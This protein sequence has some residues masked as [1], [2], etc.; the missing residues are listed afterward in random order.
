[1]SLDYYS[2]QLSFSYQGNSYIIKDIKLEN[3]TV[4][5][6]LVQLFERKKGT[7]F[8]VEKESGEL[9][10]ISGL[11]E[12]ASYQWNITAEK[13]KVR[14]VIDTA[15][16]Q[17]NEFLS[18]LEDEKV[19]RAA[20]Q[21]LFDKSGREGIGRLG[22]T[23]YTHKLLKCDN[24][25]SRSLLPSNTVRLKFPKKHF[26]DLTSKKFEGKTLPFPLKMDLGDKTLNYNFWMLLKRKK[27]Q[28]YR[29]DESGRLEK[30]FRFWGFKQEQS[31]SDKVKTAVS[32][33]IQGVNRYVAK[34]T[35]T[36]VHQLMIQRI[37]SS[38]IHLQRT[39]DKKTQESSPLCRMGRE[40]F[41]RGAINED[42]P[43][44]KLLNTELA[45]K[46]AGLVQALKVLRDV[47]DKTAL[48][49]A[50]R[51]VERAFMDLAF[52]E[53]EFTQ[54]LGV[55]LERVSDGG[56]G[57]AR[58]AR[59]RFGK[60]ILV[61]KPGDEGPLEVNN[62]QWYARLKRLLLDPKSCLEGN[63][64]QMAEID[65]WS[66]DRSFEI[67]SVPPTD[68]RFVA[69]DNFVRKRY[70]ECSVQMFVDGCVPLSKYTGISS[71]VFW[72]PR[73]F[74][75]W[76]CGSRY[77]TGPF[78]SIGQREK[79][80]EELREK[81]PLRSMQ[82]VGIKD[83]GTENIDCHPENILVK[84][85]KVSSGSTVPGRLFSGDWSVSDTEIGDFV[86]HLFNPQENG[87][88]DLLGQLFFSERLIIDGE[89]KEVTLITHDGGASNP[90]KH[91]GWWD[92]L[93][94]R[95]KHHF[96]VFPHFEEMFT[97][98]TKNFVN[99]KDDVFAGF[100]LEKGVRNLR[101]ILTPDVF[102]KF[103]SLESNRSLYKHWVFEQ[104]RDS[105]YDFRLRLI[106]ALFLATGASSRK[107]PYYQF[108][109]NYHLKRIH[110][111]LQTRI[112]SFYAMKKRVN[113]DE[114]KS[115]DLFKDVTSH[116]DF[117]RELEG[118]NDPCDSVLSQWQNR[119]VKG[120]ELTVEEFPKD[121]L[122][123]SFIFE[124]LGE[125]R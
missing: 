121:L 61:I 62:P 21:Y 45:K 7:H 20:V 89:E 122:D 46:R 37:F 94:L 73:C 107:G 53:F 30:K 92:W 79:K 69:S 44:E 38:K 3:A 113:S 82:R 29:V 117:K 71:F 1:M 17:F 33:A 119:E 12:R 123:T 6:N 116:T 101:S 99:G 72:F 41:D 15:L 36:E 118:L 106:P 8:R 50:K 52:E 32:A 104:D 105:A 48:Q 56:S 111:N 98:E 112:E 63:P 114:H 103:W 55:D 58:Y 97:E 95:N 84:A 60:K 49:A 14:E 42:S 78:Y 13:E 10:K 80:K 18:R 108:Y 115:R 67:W 90:H 70:K 96:E 40:I 31:E 54:R 120:G 100:L 65:S 24:F 51:H 4:T 57:G 93:S 110:G 91:P 43:L 125:G 22:K 109:F 68:V 86:A 59:N 19:A 34:N 75:R 2:T 66:W 81:L 77:D 5:E 9:K 83:F 35:M 28:I 16:A 47:S 87:N 76:Y 11:R 25:I 27:G 64:E 26:V 102:V 39:I 74:Q 124:G 23:L 88:Q 85:K